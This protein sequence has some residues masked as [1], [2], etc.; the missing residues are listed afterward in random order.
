MTIPKS[1]IIHGHTVTVNIVEFCENPTEFG[2][3]NDAAE[4]ITVATSVKDENDKVVELTQTQIEHTFW[5]E[6]I[7][8]FQFHIKG[9]CDETEAQ[10]FAGLLVEFFNTSH[11]KI[12]PNVIYS[13][14][15]KA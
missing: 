11:V 4:K 2:N 9:S 1:F 10:S 8:C 6:L 3:Y 14:M 12:D 15:E 13:P 5:H 7:H